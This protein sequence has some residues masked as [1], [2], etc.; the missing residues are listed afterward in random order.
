MWPKLYVG[1]IVVII[2]I[3]LQLVER[4]IT[5]VNNNYKLDERYGVPMKCFSTAL[6]GMNGNILLIFAIYMI[7]PSSYFEKVLE[8]M[9]P[10]KLQ[11]TASE[12]GLGI[13]KLTN[14]FSGEIT[15]LVD[16]VKGKLK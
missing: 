11:K 10:K 2:L 16:G 3:F 6:C 12:D 13:D 14:S 4:L 7:I 1:I 9:D 5:Y 8:I 15:E